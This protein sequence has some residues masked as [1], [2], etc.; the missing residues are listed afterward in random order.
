MNSNV[1]KDVY[2]AV[3]QK[4]KIVDYLSEKTGMEWYMFRHSGE[5]TN[6][7]KPYLMEMVKGFDEAKISFNS[8]KEYIDTC[9]Y[10]IQRFG[11]KVRL[12]FSFTEEEFE[13]MKET[14]ER[15]HFIN[16]VDFIITVLY[17]LIM[18]G[19]TYEVSLKEFSKF[20][21]NKAKRIQIVIPSEIMEKLYKTDF[22]NNQQSYFRKALFWQIYFGKTMPVKY[23]DEAYFRVTPQKTGW[24]K[25]LFQCSD[26]IKDYARNRNLGSTESIAVLN[27]LNTY[28]DQTVENESVEETFVK[29]AA[30]G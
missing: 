7:V 15:N 10:C 20:F 28:L 26:I 8:H 18:Q 22:K 24:F 13:L 27:I 16:M 29:E 30:N 25:T 12:T 3:E 14:A 6:A 23:E 17:A 19:K 21:F 4:E 11:K 1:K 2:I 9:E 5:I